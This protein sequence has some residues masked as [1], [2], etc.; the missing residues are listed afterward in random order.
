M[1]TPQTHENL[2]PAPSIHSSCPPDDDRS[3]WRS[4]E[5]EDSLIEANLI[6]PPVLQ[7]PSPPPSHSH[8]AGSTDPHIAEQQQTKR[9][10]IDEEASAPDMLS[11]MSAEADKQDES[12]LHPLTRADLGSPSIGYDFSNIRV[13]FMSRDRRCTFLETDLSLSLYLPLLHPSCARVADSKVPNNRSG[14][15]MKSRLKSSML[16]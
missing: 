9:M 1:P 11:P 3:S 4:V 5:I 2:V 10:D 13:R 6:A 15:S 14:K 7:Q 16:T 12:E 8:T